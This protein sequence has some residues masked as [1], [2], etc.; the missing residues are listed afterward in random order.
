[1]FSFNI[2]YEQNVTN[3]FVVAACLKYVQLDS[4]LT[5]SRPLSE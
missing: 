5:I 2:E 1:M 3:L 4:S